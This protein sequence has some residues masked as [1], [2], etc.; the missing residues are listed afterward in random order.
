MMAAE[1]RA[2]RVPCRRAR[3]RCDDV[4]MIPCRSL[5]GA[6]L[7]PTQA[8]QWAGGST[9]VYR[10]RGILVVLLVVAGERGF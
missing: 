3:A 5:P 7:S 1:Q 2:E 6:D 9:T 10:R 8:L 4:V